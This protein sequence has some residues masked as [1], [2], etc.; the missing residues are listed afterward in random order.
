MGAWPGERGDDGFFWMMMMM[1][2]LKMKQPQA[3][4]VGQISSIS[5]ILTQA[6]FS[7]VNQPGKGKFPW[8]ISLFEA[9]FLPETCQIRRHQVSYTP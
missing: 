3:Q 8:N 1:M 2:K 6:V 9:I 4:L 5:S 7:L